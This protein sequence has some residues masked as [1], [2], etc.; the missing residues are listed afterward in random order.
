MIFFQIQDLIKVL[1]ITGSRITLTNDET[2]DIMKV[3]KS[4]ENGDIPVRE[5]TRKG[6]VKKE[7]F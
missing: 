2:K 7:D 1:S 4:L 5:T 3:V 6:L